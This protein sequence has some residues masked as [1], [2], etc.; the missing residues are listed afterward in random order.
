VQLD[1]VNRRVVVT[2]ETCGFGYAIA[3]PA[4]RRDD[5]PTAPLHIVR[6]MFSIDE[7]VQ[8]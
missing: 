7:Q 8:R 5:P 6:D 2:G 3:Q 4:S 1:L